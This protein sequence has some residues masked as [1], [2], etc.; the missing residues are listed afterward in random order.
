MIYPGF[1]LKANQ[2]LN[3]SIVEAPLTITY[4]H[5]AT[6]KWQWSLFASYLS[7]TVKWFID[8]WA[9]TLSIVLQEV[10]TLK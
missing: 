10:A 5:M 8:S 2:S 1:S 6:L 7:V 9:N 3:T 4:E